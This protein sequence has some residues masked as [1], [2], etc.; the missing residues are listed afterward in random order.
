MDDMAVDAT[1]VIQK[2]VAAGIVDL[3]LSVRMAHNISTSK[4]GT[5]VTRSL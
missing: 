3:L 2:I 1:T 4:S 5:R